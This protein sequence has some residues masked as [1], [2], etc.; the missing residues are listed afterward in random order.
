MPHAPACPPPP[1]R[2]VW[3]GPTWTLQ[4]LCG[5]RRRARPQATG[6]PPWHTLLPSRGSEGVRA[7]HEPTMHTH[8]KSVGH[9]SGCEEAAPRQAARA[10]P[11]YPDLIQHRV[12][13]MD[14]NLS[15]VTS[16]PCVLFFAR[17]WLCVRGVRIFKKLPSP[18][19][20][21]IYSC[22]YSCC[23]HVRHIFWWFYVCSV[24]YGS[25]LTDGC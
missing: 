5:T 2:R 14:P 11:P 24:Q 8:A 6:Q 3:S 20:L 9:G 1:P 18:I 7:A 23:K 17:L 15:P 4:A 22:Q 16:R 10:Y 12:S 21:L 25:L 13:V 19:L